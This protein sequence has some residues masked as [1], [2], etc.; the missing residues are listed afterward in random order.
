M[1]AAAKAGP[2]PFGDFK[3]HINVLM[4][5]K[6]QADWNEAINN[7][8]HAI[9]PELG[10]WPG[11]FIV[12]RHGESVLATLQI[13]DTHLTHSFLLKKEHPPR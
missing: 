11:G 10:L 3:K 13:V 1:D 8:L 5:H 6:W 9:Y 7:K 12:V 4:K 2:I